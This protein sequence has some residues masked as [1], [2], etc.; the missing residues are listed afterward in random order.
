MRGFQ[1]GDTG[2]SLKIGLRSL[3]LGTHPPHQYQV[4]GEAPSTHGK[5]EHT[6]QAGSAFRGP[7]WRHASITTKGPYH[8]VIASFKTP[9]R[10]TK[11]TF[12]EAVDVWLRRW[13]GQLTHEIAAAYVINPGRVSNV[14]NEV[15]HIGSK[16][17][18]ASKRSA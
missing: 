14:L 6:F 16:E 18:A 15:T 2:K 17:V 9:P 10:K 12:D 11:F 5:A 8:W 7:S 3:A 13:S 4:L 1:P